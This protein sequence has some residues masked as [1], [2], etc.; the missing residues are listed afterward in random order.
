LDPLLH[1]SFIPSLQDISK[2]WHLQCE[3]HPTQ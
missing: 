2:D 1:L 3:S